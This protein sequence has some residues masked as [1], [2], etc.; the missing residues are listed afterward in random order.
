M[1]FGD[2]DSGSLI[3]SLG[4][5]HHCTESLT[6]ISSNVK[7]SIGKGGQSLLQTN[8]FDVSS[9]VSELEFDRLRLR[10]YLGSLLL[11]LILS[12]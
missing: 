10:A 3:V 4:H 8:R 1:K 12:K 5:V 2:S 9:L 11:S 7:L 6:N